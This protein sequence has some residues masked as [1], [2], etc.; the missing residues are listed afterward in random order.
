MEPLTDLPQA[1]RG[2]PLSSP[3]VSEPLRPKLERRVI[4]AAETALASQKFVAPVD[5]LVRLNWLPGSLPDAW[6]QGQ[7][8]YLVERA[9]V[10]E[11][12]LMTAL[13]YLRSWAREHGLEPSETDY[14]AA[15]RGHRP[16]RFTPEGDE[17]TERLFRTHWLSPN[18]PKATRDRLVARQNK[19]PDLVAVETGEDWT[20]A[21]CGDTGAL[22]VM[23]DDRPHCLGCADLDHLV[24]LPA[25]NAALS[26]RAKQHSTLSAV[27]VWFNRPRK[28]FQRRGVL[29]E[30]EAL[31][32]AEEQCLA[33]AE[34]RERRRVRDAE[35]RAHEDVEYQAEFAQRVRAEF[36]GCPPERAL[37]IAQ[38]AGLRGSGRVGRTAAARVFDTEAVTLAVIASVRH[39]DTDYDQ[40]LMSGVPRMVARERIA[41][42]IDAVL[43]AWRTRS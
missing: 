30:A 28:R 1:V 16:L 17:A 38:H 32:R 23:E 24:F 3:V 7:V 13:G 18:L 9:A 43:T 8:E 39:L 22:R 40:L 12:K 5:V 29:V 27:V 34:V 31:E 41:G 33:D 11:E 35:R 21:G 19:A 2:S 4:A 10:T 14:L 6:R 37:A 42:R 15:S 20:C 25:G 36:P 26:R